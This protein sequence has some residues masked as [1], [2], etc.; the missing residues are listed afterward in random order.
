MTLQRSR[1]YGWQTMKSWSG[2]FVPGTYH[3]LLYWCKGTG[4]YTYRTTMAGV[5]VEGLSWFRESS[6]R[7]WS[8]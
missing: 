3:G 5:T 4:T 1:W 6:H 2:N 8:C 7:R